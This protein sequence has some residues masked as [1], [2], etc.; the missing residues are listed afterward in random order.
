MPSQ[1]TNTPRSWP[2]KR[3]RSLG[4]TIPCPFCI[5]GCASRSDSEQSQKPGTLAPSAMGRLRP[6]L[7]PQ[8][9]N[10]SMFDKATNA[11]A[12]IAAVIPT[13]R[14]RSALYSKRTRKQGYP[15]DNCWDCNSAAQMTRSQVLLHCKNPKLTVARLEVWVVKNSQ[16][17][18]TLLANPGWKRRFVR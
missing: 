2:V 7:P 4:H 11:A 16:G 15:N 10:K 6:P 9:R 1:S 18:R 17:V 3:Q 5:S 8:L 13:G 12:R 14:W